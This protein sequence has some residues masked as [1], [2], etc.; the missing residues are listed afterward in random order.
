M[1]SMVYIFDSDKKLNENSFVPEALNLEDYED[2][3]VI[4]YFQTH[5]ILKQKFIYHICD[6]MMSLQKNKQI[7]D[8]FC[9]RCRSKNPTHNIKENIRKNSIFSDINIPI[10][11]K[12]NLTFNCFLKNIDV[13]KT[14]INNLSFCDKIRAPKTIP[15]SIIKL[16]RQLRDCIRL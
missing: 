15:E 7:L 5:G 16:F 14:Y 9:S 3:E 6:K 11:S 2:R 8:L 10:N 13:N 12:Y 4:D 1:N